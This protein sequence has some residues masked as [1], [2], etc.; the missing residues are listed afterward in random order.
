LR[1]LVTKCVKRLYDKKTDNSL[2]EFQGRFVIFLFFLFL[3][4][5]SPFE[6]YA[7]DSTVRD[8][9]RVAYPIN[10][11]KIRMVSE[12]ITIL[13]N[14]SPIIVTCDFVLENLTDKEVKVRVG[15]PTMDYTQ[16]FMPRQDGS[17]YLYSDDFPLS[18]SNFKVF[19]SDEEVEAEQRTETIK[20]W[21]TDTGVDSKVMRD[22]FTW[23]MVFPPRGK[24]NTRNIY[25]AGLSSSPS[26]AVFKYILKTGRYWKGTIK[27][28]HIEAVF[29]SKED[30]ISE[31]TSISPKGFIIDGNR[32]IWKYADFEPR[33]DIIIGIH[34]IT[35]KDI[36]RKAH[37]ILCRNNNKYDGATKPYTLE[38]ISFNKSID[39][40]Y[41]KERHMD[42]TGNFR[43]EK[44]VLERVNKYFAR[45]KRNEIFA[46]HGR[47]F[48]SE[49][50]RYIFKGE[51]PGFGGCPWYKL[52]PGYSDGMLNEI[53]KRNIMFILEHEEKMGWR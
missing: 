49:D 50:L 39:F 18:K 16:H 4:F 48:I 28:A 44:L 22:W 42:Y 27:Q 21:K 15:F 6:T 40:L 23:D 5:S 19:I 14:S 10:T 32:I 53:E 30:M 25:H 8:N 51:S 20:S 37:A 11:D 3:L 1:M 9:G 7:N 47:S 34:K 2:L 43:T 26:G 46:R 36:I 35:D 45:V 12:K 13:M 29:N 17:K 38:D 24:I 41:P 31:V 52:D 33:K